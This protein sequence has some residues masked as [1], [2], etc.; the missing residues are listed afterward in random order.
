MKVLRASRGIKWGPFFNFIK[1]VPFII[2]WEDVMHVLVAV[3][4][5][6]F[7]VSMSSTFTI[8]YLII[9]C[10]N[11]LLFLSVGCGGATDPVL[12]LKP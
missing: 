12:I 4:H 7:R 3:S 10:L 1:T 5:L 11:V 6:H 9:F 2:N 8:I